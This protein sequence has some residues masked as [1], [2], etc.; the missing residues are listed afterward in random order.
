SII[1]VFNPADSVTQ[2]LTT[3]IEEIKE[4][5]KVF[6]K[7]LLKKEQDILE[8]DQTI[9]IQIRQMLAR[10][11]NEELLNSLMK[12]EQ[13]QSHIQN[14]TTKVILLGAI[15]LIIVIVFLILILKD[16]TKSQL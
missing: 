8:N 2:L 7:Q 6:E 10:L 15:A 14:I 16:I 9:T 13:Q 3:V 4:E 5:S 12:V 11:E 1:D